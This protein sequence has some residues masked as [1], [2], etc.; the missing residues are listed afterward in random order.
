GANLHRSISIAFGAVFLVLLIACANI[1]SL[2]FA[3]GATRRTELAVRASLGAGRGR[4]VLQ[5]LTECLAL[6]ILGGLSGIAGAYVLIR[7]A[8]PLLSRSLPFTANV[9]LNPDVFAFAAALVLG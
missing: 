9:S 1:A 8:T 3:Q 7:A 4:L 5:L 2:L 6:C